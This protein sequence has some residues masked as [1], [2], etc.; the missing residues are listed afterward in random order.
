[1]CHCKINLSSDET[2]FHTFIP[3]NR[4]SEVRLVFYTLT[5]RWEHSHKGFFFFFPLHEMHDKIIRMCFNESG[6]QPG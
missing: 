5:W 4:K 2:N 6:W 3:Q 1:M